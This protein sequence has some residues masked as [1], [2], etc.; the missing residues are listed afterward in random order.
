MKS[1]AIESNFYHCSRGTIMGLVLALMLALLPALA[2]A[3][4]DTGTVLGTV[5][6]ST[7]ARVPKAQITLT[8]EDNGLV[9]KQMSKGNGSFE[10]TALKV[11]TYS[12]SVTS[13]GFDRVDKQHV[14]VSIQSQVEIP[15]T[16]K[17]GSATDVVT[18]ASDQVVLQ[19]QDASV[20]QVVSEREI[21][22]LPLNGR[23]YTLLAQ[24]APGTTTTYYDSG[25]GEVQSGSFTANGVNTV[26]N[27][28]LL[29]GVTNNNMTADFG[30]GNSFT[31]K[32]PPDGL[33]EFKVETANYSAEYGR[34]GGAII[35][36]VTKSGQNTLFGDV[37]E[38][39]RNAYFDAVD[40]FLKKAGLP[41]PK[42]NRNQFGFS[43]G[44]PVTIPHLYKGRD[45]T[46]FFVDYEGLRLR[47][48]QAYTSSV[49]TA[50]EQSSGFTNYA[51]LFTYQTGTQT[52]ILG[53]VTKI[54]QVFD[55]ATTRYLV[56]GKADP[57]TGLTVKSTGYARDPF[58]NNIIPSGRVDPNLVR[59][60]SQ[61]PMPNTNNGN[62]VNNYVSSPVLKQSGD[63][64]DA[65]I[66]EN[67][68]AKD[69][70][71]ARGSYGLIP[72]VIPA[73]CATIA[74]CGTSGTVGNES[75][76]ITGVAVGETH[77]FSARFVNELRIGYNRIHMNR[78]EPYGDQGGLNA[79]YG[80]S[81]IPDQSGNGGIAQIKI[82]GLAELGE[83]NNIPLNE[84]GAETQYNDNVSLELGRHSLRVGAS[85]ERIKNAI[86][87]AQYPHGNFGFSGTYTDQPSG[88]TA[89]TGVAQFVIAPIKS[90]VASGTCT[91]R[92]NT[93][94]GTTALAPVC[95]F[96]DY[97]GGTNQ[98][99]ASPLSQQDY[100]R[101]YFGTYFNDTWKVTSTFTATIGL[102]WEYF[103][104]GADHAGHAANFVPS[105]AS[106]DGT[107]KYLIDD[108]SKNVPLSP[109]FVN[110]LAQENI[111][112]VYTSNHQLMNVPEKNFSPRL[113]FAWN[114]HSGSVLRGGY[115]ISYA[116]IY[117]RGDGYNPGDDYPFTFAV[118]ITSNNQGGLAADSS[119]TAGATPSYG[120]MSAGL[121]GVPL[122]PANAPGYQ[123]S[124]R[125]IQYN[126]HI[127]Y[128]QAE[129]LSVQQQLSPSQYLQIAYV[130]TQSR[131]VESN[132]QSNQPDLILPTNFSVSPVSASATC[133]DSTLHHDIEPGAATPPTAQD[134]SVYYDQYPCLAQKNY[135]QW[136]E[137][138]NNY[139]SLQVKYQKMY[140]SGTSLI[141]SYT[142]EKL[143]G[144]GSDSNLFNSL[145]YRA[146]EV[147]GFGMAGE[148]GNLGFESNNIIHG[149]GIW[150]LPYGY[151]QKF[152][153]H[154]GLVDTLI[155]GW[156]L[157]G[158]VT[159][160]A[161]QPFTVSSCASTHSGGFG[162]YAIAN[163]STL[164]TG[165]HNVNHWINAAAF[166]DPIGSP[167]L[168]ENS[169]FSF[170]GSKPGQAYG[171]AFHRG[172]V[173]MQKEF[174]L[175][176][177]NVFQFRAEAFN[178][179]NTPNFGQP[180][181]LSY[182]NTAFA[183]ITS[184]RDSPTDAREFQFALKYIFGHGHQE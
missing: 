29:D 72:R 44:G 9:M 144:D 163:R 47:Q 70:I 170:L 67:V 108:R 91:T 168:P 35:N 46:F 142:W 120:P 147:P 8:N 143:L 99:Q 96:Y 130:A 10:F 150:A 37:W 69:Q 40:Y 121:T 134:N 71:F 109:S 153:N 146:P 39:N 106:G 22:N 95:G 169:D 141:F 30:N 154:K 160:Q 41:R 90:T 161:G 86:Y 51:D 60:I 162:C 74:L 45:R 17:L 84:I 93:V 28:Y 19:T 165:A 4:V 117:A 89:S 175:P 5:T 119:G 66:D 122:T 114:F 27:N 129:N 94:A 36:A 98:I 73:P 145:S 57:V 83:H 102:R 82:T 77:V 148:Y 118:N 52:D 59:L 34:S 155:G 63:S 133:A 64:F 55:P 158:I 76:V 113:G 164:Y 111:Q 184:N 128:V 177:P 157:T 131:H 132:I 103:Q 171:P 156:K 124:P 104:T 105:F 87:S 20:G 43:L 78:L 137:G 152:G 50:L 100:R 16:L 115:G 68:S 61:F 159:Y 31:L 25:H 12:V 79:Q 116:G 149:G 13:P 1:S 75:D 24:L 125:G 62:I 7:G 110:L 166:S 3:Q 38:Y 14:D 135:Y 101:P 26:Y 56:A 123:I 112:L 151:G 172:D 107:S 58:V 48:G 11:G 140:S 53:R 92:L 65:R 181:T 180:G 127:P 80:I 81:G 33:Q 97:V 54:G 126:T 88:N 183:S 32:P 85:Y 136:L 174:H 15:V 18:V 178:I 6:D 2:S 138:S 49:P 167:A 176:G 42:Y 173:G 139:N 179:T 182:T 21:N 23:N